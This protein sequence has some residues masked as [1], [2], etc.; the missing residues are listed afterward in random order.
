MAA[1]LLTAC[2][3]T[4]CGTRTEPVLSSVLSSAETPRDMLPGLDTAALKAAMPQDDYGAFE[5]YLP[6]L[7]GEETFQ[8]VAGPY[9]GYPDY[10]WEAREVTLADFHSELWGDSEHKTETLELDRLA[11]RDIDGDGVSELVLLVRDMAYNYLVLHREGDVV[12]GTDLYVRWF[13][14]LQQNGAYIG[15]GGAGDSTYYRMTFQNQRFEQQELGRKVEWAAGCKCTLA[16]EP[17]TEEVFDAWLAE[18]MV[19][20]VAWYLPAE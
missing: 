8:W 20:E 18:T 17:V 3:L 2:L 15:S 14:G 4:A 13:E 10:D 11:V 19:G 1:L 5:A 16:G 9:R 6:V 7:R 12:Y